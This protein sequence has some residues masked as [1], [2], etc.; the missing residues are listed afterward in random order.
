MADQGDVEQCRL[1]RELNGGETDGA[2][3]D[4]MPVV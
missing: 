1:G 3:D 4:R 2:V